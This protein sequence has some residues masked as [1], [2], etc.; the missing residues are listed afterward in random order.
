MKLNRR[1]NRR[2]ASS[3]RQLN[4]LRYGTKSLLVL[5]ALAIGIFIFSLNTASVNAHKIY[6]QGQQFPLALYS[7]HEAE[8]MQEVRQSGWNIAHTYHF[9][10]SFLET[11]AQGNMLTLTDLPGEV[12]PLPKAQMA[13]TIAALAKSDRVAWWD[14]P[15]ERRYW[16]E[17]EMAI[18]TEYAKWTRQYDPKQRPNYMYI[19]GHYSAK[20]IQQYVP[21]LDIIAASVYTKYMGMPHPWARWRM[22]TTLKGIER[23]QAKI[24]PDYLQGE[25]TPVAVL[26]LFNQ[27]GKEVMTPEGAYHDFW[28]SIVSGAR[29]ILV[30]SYFN[31]RN[32]PDLEQ[33]WQTYNKAAAEITGAEKLGSAILSGT[34]SNTVSFEI[35]S[36]PATTEKFKFRGM[37]QPL[38]YPALDL[39]TLEW[40]QNTYVFA[41][42]SANQPISAK[43]TGLPNTT[44]ATVLFENTTVPV[45]NGVL[46]ADFPPLGVHIFKVAN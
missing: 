46:N 1:R 13:N 17:G 26:E 18:V 29:G 6:P 30:Y 9:E 23:A 44:E 16:R 27:P 39:L 10:P 42:N 45:A 8:A 21:Y 19:P 34:R 11:T 32:H 24:G 7:I 4:V 3:K 36:G 5:L 14:F 37:E 2:K 12:E 15:E 25:K 40:N 33:V 28:Q 38:S 22:E 31:R 20:D 35:V 41:V 43:I